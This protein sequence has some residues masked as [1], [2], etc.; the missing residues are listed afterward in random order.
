MSKA[1]VS[2]AFVGP[3]GAGKTLALGHLCRLL[4][5]FSEEQQDK[6]AN[7]AK[8]MGRPQCKDAWLLDTLVEERELGSTISPSLQGFESS[9]FAYTAIDTPGCKD[10]FTNLVSVASMADVATLVVSAAPQEFESQV[11]SGR[12]FQLALTCFTMGIKNIAVAVTKMDHPSVGFASARFEEVK[13]QVGGFLKEVGYK[14]GKDGKEVPFVPVSGLNGDNLTTKSS[15]CGWYGGKTLIETLDEMGPI[16]RPAEKP[17]RLP[18]F[19]AQDVPGTG[20]VITGRVETGTVRPGIKLKFCPGGQE[21]EVASVQ[22]DGQ[23]VSEAKGGDI[24]TVALEEGVEIDDVRRGSVASSA[25]E[26]SDPAVETESFL[27]QVMI[28]DHPGS[29]RAGYCPSIAIHTAQIPCEFEKLVAQIDRKTKSEN[30]N[31][32]KV[33]TG[34]AVTVRMKPRGHV[35]IESFSVFPSLGRF[36][37]RD[38]GRTVAV[39]VVKEVTK[40]SLPKARKENQYGES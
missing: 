28:L 21:A 15:Q 17:L 32:E 35:C 10:F 2:V 19:K 20:V 13:K 16:N 25:G 8:E 3:E 34:D 23:Q 31:P 22:K 24:V 40:R 27:A 30:P 7:L 4:G 29:I 6:C 1:S 9:G 11:D 12:I 36:S 38:H 39:G 37:V 33:K 14:T 18:V 26:T 5:G